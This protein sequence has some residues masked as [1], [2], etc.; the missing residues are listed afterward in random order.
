MDID[1]TELVATL[2]KTAGIDPDTLEESE[3]VLI[4]FAATVIE[5]CAEQV[6]HLGIERKDQEYGDAVRFSVEA[7]TMLRAI[8]PQP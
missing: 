5:F 7:G 3:D 6:E 1:P 4:A 2:A 8:I